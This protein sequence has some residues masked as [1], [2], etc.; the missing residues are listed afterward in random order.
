MC[1]SAGYVNDMNVQ[2]ILKRWIECMKIHWMGR[3]QNGYRVL[4]FDYWKTT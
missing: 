3:D 1:N 4:E 2:T